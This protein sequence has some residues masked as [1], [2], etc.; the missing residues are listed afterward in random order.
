MTD[1][2]LYAKLARHTAETGSPL[3]VLHGDHVGFLGVVYPTR[4]LTV[5]RRARRAGGVR[6]RRTSSTRCSSRAPRSPCT[7]S[8]A[9]SRGTRARSSSRC[10]PWPCP[11]CVNA[12]FVMSEAAAY[13]VFLWA[14]LACHAAVSE[15]SARRDALA[16]RSPGARVLHEAAVPLPRRGPAHRGADRGRPT[17]RLAAASAAGGRLRGGDPPRRPAR[18]A[19]RGHRLLGDYG[20]TATQGRCSPRSPGS[21]PRSTST[22]SRSVSASCR[23]SSAPAGRTR[24]SATPIAAAAHSRPSPALALP[25]LALETASYDVRFGGPD[26]VRDRYLFYL[27]PLLLLATASACS[28]T[29]F[30]S[31]GSPEST[32]FFSAT[33]VF[34][35]F[36]PVAGLW[37]D[38]PESVLNGVIHD[39]VRRRCRPASSSPSAGSCSAWSASASPW[40]RGRPPCSASTSPSS[41]SAERRRLCVRSP[42][43][44]QHAA[45]RPDHRQAAR[46][47]LGRPLVPA[48]DRSRC[49]RTRSPA[50]GA[51]AQ[52]CGGTPSS[53]TTAPDG[54]RRPRR[55][56]HLHAVPQHGP[57]RS[58]SPPDGSPGPTTRRRSSSS[59]PNDSRFGLAGAQTA[60]N[61]GLV[62]REVERPYRAAWATRGLDS[63]G[64]TRPRP[65]GHDPGLRG[66]GR[67]RH[68]SRLR[69]CSTRRRRRA[70][71]SPTGSASRAGRSLRERG[72]TGADGLHPARRAR[73]P[74]ARG[75]PLGGDRRA[76]RSAPTPGPVRDVGVALSGVLVT[77]ERRPC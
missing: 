54:L 2:L 62:L 31:P 21:R 42:A 41:A 32:A 4:A 11:W 47:G 28:T 25:L 45:G 73:R 64:W 20:V 58:T 56:V 17:R 39:A 9:G 46:A 16:R 75:G 52:S 63:D 33:V 5:L 38:S 61:V 51:R 6:R 12:A 37:V 1:E 66:T 15:P 34:A 26:V 60:A 36:A 22:S 14:V 23:S 27:A 49:S 29:G 35:D 74:H 72:S 59:A 57:A 19:R 44:E 30:R 53:G 70:H 76:R 13:P 10:C 18:R 3:P 68:A 40:S 77:A 24:R 43:D 71:R 67:R 65:A 55:H 48:G 7:C 8:P 69:R 50:T